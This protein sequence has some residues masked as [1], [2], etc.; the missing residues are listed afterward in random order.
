MLAREV[1]LAA[2]LFFLADHA[3]PSDRERLATR[4]TC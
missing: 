4:K 2:E 3:E 1:I